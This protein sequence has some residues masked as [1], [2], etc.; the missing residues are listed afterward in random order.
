MPTANER[1]TL[2]SD[3]ITTSGLSDVVDTNGWYRA[4]VFWN[5]T[6]GSSS[7]TRT[8]S[9]QVYTSTASGTSDMN[10]WVSINP[11]D[12]A[13]TVVG[14]TGHATAFPKA[15]VGRFENFARYLVASYSTGGGAGTWSFDNIAEMKGVN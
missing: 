13:F 4:I 9:C 8:V 1:K 2:K 12:G 6:N 14:G 10:D 5:V 15:Q 3:T 11:E 7:S